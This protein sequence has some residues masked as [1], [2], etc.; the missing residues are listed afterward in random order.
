M[1]YLRQLEEQYFPDCRENAR[2]I[3]ISGHIRPDGDCV[4][5][6]LGLCTYLL[7][8]DPDLR[9]DVYLDPIPPEFSFLKNADRVRQENTDRLVYDLC[10]A[11]DCSDPERLNRAGEIFESAGRTVCIDHHITNGGFGDISIVCPQASSASELLYYLLRDKGLFGDGEISVD[12]AQAL[13]LGIVHDTGVFKHNN[14]TLEAMTAAGELM[15]YGLDTE[16]IINDTFYKK[17][18]KQNQLLGKALLESILMLDGRMIFSALYRKDFEIFACEDKDADGIIDQ[19]RVTD[20]IH[21]A[22]LLY[23]TEEGP[24]KVSLRSDELVDVAAIAKEFGGGGHIRAAGCSVYGEVNDI[25]S[26]IAARVEFQ[27]AKT[28]E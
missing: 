2:T 15:G 25:V 27:L 11:L 1:S 4:G 23:E 18:Y 9:V 10:V 26:N 28:H 3:A 21:V 6:C 14:T 19:L 16:K 7:D 12:C 8:R 20:G 24:F 13:Y 5:A 22:L 17:T